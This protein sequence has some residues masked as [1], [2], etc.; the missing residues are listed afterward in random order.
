MLNEVNQ[1]STPAGAKVKHLANVSCQVPARDSSD[2][3]LCQKDTQHGEKT[4]KANCHIISKKYYSPSCE[5][6][7]V[8]LH[9]TLTVYFFTPLTL[10]K[11]LAQAALNSSLLPRYNTVWKVII[12]QDTQHITNTA[13]A[14]YTA[15]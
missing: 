7:T 10:A 13:I 2:A 4:F 11:Y 12:K 5:R 6:R 15:L 8:T 9:K 14:I 3:T 1:R